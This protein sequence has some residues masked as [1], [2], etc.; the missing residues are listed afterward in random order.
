[1]LDSVPSWCSASD[2]DALRVLVRLAVE[3]Y[4]YLPD[5]DVNDERDLIY[6]CENALGAADS[7]FAV[8]AIYRVIGDQP[9]SAIA[10]DEISSAS[11]KDS[12]TS[13]YHAFSNGVSFEER[14]RL[15][16]DLIRLR[17]IFAGMNYS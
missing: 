6:Q 2:R 14:C 1:M 15:L 9:N 17:I 4:Y 12:Y 3:F 10:K 5:A 16:L 8:A 11:L 13:K 7:F